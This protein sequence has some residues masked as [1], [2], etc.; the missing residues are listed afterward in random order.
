MMPTVIEVLSLTKTYEMADEKTMALDH[1]SLVVEKGEY[2]AIIGPSGSGKSTLLNMLGCLD[3]P[4]SGA[5]LLDGVDVA[6][7]SPKKLAAI[8]SRRI[9]FVFQSFNLLQRMTV[10]ENVMMPLIYTKVPHRK[11]RAQA[12]Y[13]LERAGLEASRF[14]HKANQ[15]SGGQSQ[16]VAIARALVNEPTIILADEPTGNLDSAT[17]KMVLATFQELN[18]QGHTIVLITHDS[19]VAARAKRVVRIQDG[20][21]FEVNSFYSENASE[22]MA[23]VDA[24]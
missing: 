3:S 6:K 4:T 19:N 12:I 24:S 13:M 18:E 8:R 7:L 5:Y 23:A 17:G 10:L 2:V 15:L 16:R 22:A 14:N 1:V 9:G 20:H 11:R 21:L